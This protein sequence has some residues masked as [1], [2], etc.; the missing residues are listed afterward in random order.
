MGQARPRSLNVLLTNFILLL[1]LH[2]IV[3]LLLP[4]IVVVAPTVLLHVIIVAVPT[5]LLHVTVTA[6]PTVLPRAIVI[7]FSTVEPQAFVDA[8]PIIQ[9]CTIV[10]V[11]TI[12][13]AT[14]RRGRVVISNLVL[15]RTIDLGEISP[16]I[17]G[18]VFASTC[19]LTGGFVSLSGLCSRGLAKEC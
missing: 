17:V 18:V 2:A 8:V 6:I 3:S 4:L 1:L 13:I 10:A 9:R 16:I 14:I 7:A 11:S 12:I 5:I 19:I 15:I